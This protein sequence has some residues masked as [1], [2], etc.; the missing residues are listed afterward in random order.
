MECAIVTITACVG[1]RYGENNVRNT[2]NCKFILQLS[3]VYAGS[4]GDSPH[5]WIEFHGDE[6][7][8]ERYYCFAS[9]EQAHEAREDILRGM[10]AGVM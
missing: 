7:D 4:D 2:I 5:F 3:Q 8:C 9:T 10:I 1:W 6:S